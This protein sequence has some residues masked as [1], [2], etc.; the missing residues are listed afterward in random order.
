MPSTPDLGT[1]PPRPMS[2]ELE[3]TG[4]LRFVSRTAGASFVLDSEGVAG[5]SPMQ[6]V[7]SALA[8]CMGMDV[9]HFLARSRVPATSVRISMTG[10]RAPGSPSRFVEIS[11][12]FEIRAAASDAQVERALRLS[13]EKYCSVW[14]SMS[15]DISLRIST[16]LSR[17]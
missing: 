5:P 11:L 16:G 12:H 14:N 4:D 3:W 7:A 1:P 10:K 6:A 9:V 17:P 2:S 13:R 8:G 15:P